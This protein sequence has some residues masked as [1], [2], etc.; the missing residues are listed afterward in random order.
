MLNFIKKKHSNRVG[1]SRRSTDTVGLY[2][3]KN[4]YSKILLGLINYAKNH[5][6]Y[7]EVFNREVF[8]VYCIQI[9]IDYH[10][11]NKRRFEY[12]KTTLQQYLAELT[13]K[14]TKSNL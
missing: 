1:L 7:K 9:M 11:C 13:A 6:D 10:S 5:V 12:N 2:D 8:R 4:M 3:A 14:K